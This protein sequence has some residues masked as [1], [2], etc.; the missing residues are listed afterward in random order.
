MNQHFYR[1]QRTKSGLNLS[2]IYCYYLLSVLFLVFVLFLLLLL[3]LLLVRLVTAVAF[4]APYGTRALSSI[5]TTST[6]LL[7]PTITPPV[8]PEWNL[9]PTRRSVLTLR[10][11][12]VPVDL[13]RG[14]CIFTRARRSCCEVAIEASVSEGR[15]YILYSILIIISSSSPIK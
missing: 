6:S 3:L 1:L 9:A 5:Y 14:L 10:P 4:R 7:R 15:H 13:L 2:N 12:A 8:A 11:R